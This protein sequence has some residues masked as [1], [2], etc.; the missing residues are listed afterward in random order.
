MENKNN[1][2]PVVLAVVGHCN[3]FFL[4][5]IKQAIERLPHFKVVFIKTSA[6]KLY[7]MGEGGNHENR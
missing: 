7:I 5:E 3:P 2:T 6:G 4:E 1:D